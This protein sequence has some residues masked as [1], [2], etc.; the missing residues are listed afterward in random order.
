MDLKKYLGKKIKII[1]DR[2]LGSNHAK[3]DFVYEVNYGYVPETKAPDGE[4]VDAYL[5]GVDEPVGEYTGKCIAIVHRI[6]DDDDKLII[7]SERAND[8]SNGEIIRQINFQ[9]KY[10]D[11]E[12]QR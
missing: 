1:I 3:Y 5:L 10:F 11:S 2:P 6:N 7:A 12:I 4:E 8:L 9:E